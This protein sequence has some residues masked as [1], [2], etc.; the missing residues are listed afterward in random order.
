MKT[1]KEIRATLDSLNK[2]I[3]EVFK[4]EEVEF[5]LLAV[6]YD[7][8]NNKTRWAGTRHALFS[9]LPYFLNN[10]A[11]MVADALSGRIVNEDKETTKDE[12]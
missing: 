7:R 9:T 2:H 5:T 10:C 6:F 12:K 1:D 11:V 8:E 3:R 4:D